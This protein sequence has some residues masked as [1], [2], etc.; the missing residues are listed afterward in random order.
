MKHRSSRNN[1][2]GSQ[3]V[4]FAVGLPLIILLALLVA[5]GANMFRVFQLVTNAAREGA[6]LSTLPQ[7]RY[8]AINNTTNYNL[9]NPQT[10]TFDATNKTN[11]HP[12]CQ[13]VANYIQYNNAVGSNY[14]Q[15][16]S[17]AVTVNQGFSPTNDSGNSHYSGVSVTCPYS[18]RFLPKLPFYTIASTI[19]ITRRT[20]LRNFY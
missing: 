17:L 18:L 1:E 8:I 11:N 3:I 10:C 6:R 12:V 13:A 9:T 16:P 4:E 2:R 19:S 14:A 15:C 7:D 20:A 5:E